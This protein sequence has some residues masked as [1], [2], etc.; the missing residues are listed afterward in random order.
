MFASHTNPRRVVFSTELGW[1]ALV[2][3]GEVLGRLVFGYSSAEDAEWALGSDWLERSRAAPW[4]RPLQRRLRDYA[5]DQCVEFDDVPVAMDDLTS[6]A[7]KVILALREV[8]YGHTTTY[9]ELASR[10]G[11]PKTARS[12]GKLMAAN[13]VPLVVPC[14][15]VVYAGGRIGHYSAPGGS[16][17]KRRLLQMERRWGLA[18]IIH[19]R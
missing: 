19:D 4:N 10:V 9:G 7:R 13:P 16:A 6:F 17:T 2:G 1:M 8:R 11:L 14:H 5:A 15:R 3:T 12:V 18:R